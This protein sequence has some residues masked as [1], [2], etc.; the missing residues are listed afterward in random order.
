[1]KTEMTEITVT[2]GRRTIQKKPSMILKVGGVVYPLLLAFAG[3]VCLIRP[4]M[5]AWAFMWTVALLIFAGCKWLTWR[6]AVAFAELRSRNDKMQVSPIW[7]RAGY[8]LAWVGMDA[9]SFLRTSRPMAKPGRPQWLFAWAKVGFGAAVLWG[10]VRLIP[11]SAELL[12]GWVGLIGL[13]FLLHFGLFHLLALAWQR[14]GVDAPPIMRAPVLATSVADFWGRRWNLAF[15]RLAH[16]MVFRPLRRNL[17]VPFA[18][19]AVFVVSGLVHEIVISFPARGG[20]GG[21]MLYFALQALPVL[22]ERIWRPTGWRA[23]LWTLSCV[24]GPVGFLFH[25]PFINQVILP[26]MKVIGAF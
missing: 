7:I 16:E 12:R 14:A 3:F 15:H 20:Y 4:Q 5:P 24:A 21:P 1:M 22:S 13:V 25:P 26:F 9:E 11:A 23:R 8:L 2:M 10:T 18:T 6:R 19:I 17:G